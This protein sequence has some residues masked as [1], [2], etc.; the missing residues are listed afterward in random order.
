MY[1][2]AFSLAFKNVTQCHL[3]ISHLKGMINLLNLFDYSMKSF[4]LLFNETNERDI[5]RFFCKSHL[6]QNYYLF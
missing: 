3:L 6:N 4:M 5:D 1:V 2:K